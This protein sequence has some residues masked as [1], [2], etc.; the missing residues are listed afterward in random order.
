MTDKN[1]LT[2]NELNYERGAG[3]IWFILAL[4]YYPSIISGMFLSAVSTSFWSLVFFLV[5]L[6]LFSLT[7]I[8]QLPHMVGALVMF[9]QIIAYPFQIIAK[10]ILEGFKND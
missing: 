8:L 3:R 4:I 7:I 5:V 9:F 1:A 6:P 10:W 2:K